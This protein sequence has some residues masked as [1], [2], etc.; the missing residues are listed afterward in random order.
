MAFGRLKLKPWEFYNYTFEEFLITVKGF[1]H[2]ETEE[3]KRARLIAWAAVAPYQKTQKTPQDWLPLP[4]EKVE[5]ELTYQKA[6][7]LKEKY[8]KLGL[9][10]SN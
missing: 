1:W 10:R 5:S 4:G 7:E 3:W 9:L 2:Q 6:L 8:Y